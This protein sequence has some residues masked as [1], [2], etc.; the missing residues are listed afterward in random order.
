M[1]LTFDDK[2]TQ[3]AMST[4][5]FHVVEELGLTCVTRKMWWVWFHQRRKGGYWACRRHELP[6]QSLET[7]YQW[8]QFVCA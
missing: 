4:S 1:P 7:K 6:R 2:A 3:E 5:K 8:G